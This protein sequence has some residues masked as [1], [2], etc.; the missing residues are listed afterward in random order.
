[1][2]SSE[3]EMDKLD[4]KI[5]TLGKFSTDIE[6]FLPDATTNVL[7]MD[8]PTIFKQVTQSLGKNSYVLLHST[9]ENY[10]DFSAENFIKIAQK[11]SEG[12][13]YTLLKK[14]Q[15]FIPKIPHSVHSLTKTTSFLHELYSFF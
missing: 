10:S 12:S 5:R 1:M 14:V 3:R 8:N 13:S 2:V 7:L 11:Y 4:S 9:E 6:R 15:F